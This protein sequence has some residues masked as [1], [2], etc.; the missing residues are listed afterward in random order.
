MKKLFQILLVVVLTSV[1][2]MA[3]QEKTVIGTVV[4]QSDKEPLIGATVMA[5]GTQ[6]GVATDIDGHFSLVIPSSVHDLRVSYV[7][8]ET[9][10]V[11]VDFNFPM[12]ISLSDNATKLDDVIVV[13]YGTAKKSEYTGAASVVSA[14]DIS[15]ALV[16][17][18]T[19][20]LQGK[21]SG[22]QTLSSDGRPGGQ[23]SV[24]IRGVGSINA[25]ND[26]L[27]V[28]DGVPY[29]GDISQLANSDIESMTVLKDAASTALYGARGANGVV[30]ITTKKG[31]TGEARVTLEAR[32]GQNA[33]ALDNYN[34]IKSP[35][36]YYEMLYQGYYNYAT[37]ERGADPAT[38]WNFA[39]NQIQPLNGTG[40][41][42]GYQIW[43]VPTG[44]RLV[45]HN[46][47]LNPNATLGYSDGQ[48]YY[49]PDDWT[50]G[51]I[52]KGLRQ[53]YN[54]GVSGGSEKFKYYVSASYLGDEGIIQ[55]SGFNRL[56]T[57]TTVDYQAKSW[58]KIGTNMAYI[59]TN[60]DFAGSQTLND[61]TSSGN[62]FY[63]VNSLAPIYPM[64]VRDASGSV[65]HN[66]TYNRPIYDY[67]DGYSTNFK[68]AYMSMSNPAGDQAYNKDKFLSDA[69][70]GKWFVTLTPIK[71]LNITGTAGFFTDNTRRHVVDNPFYGQSAESGGSAMQYASRTS[72]INLQALAS[73]S[74]TFAD[75]HNMD[76]MVGF[77]NY[78]LTREY[79]YGLGYN[80]Y[81][82][83][84]WNVSNVIDRK[85]TDGGRDI[86]YTTCGF[87]GRAKYNYDGRY[88]VQA[89]YRRD[90]SS[91]FAPGHRWGNFYSASVGWD[92]SREAF[93]RD[94]TAV[95][96]LKFKF[97][98]GQNGNDKLSADMGLYPQ[99][100]YAWQDQYQA[101]GAN[102]VWNDANLIYKG[103][104][105]ITWETSSAINTGFDFSFFHGRLD[106]TIEY[107]SRQTRNMLFNLPAAPSLGYSSYPANV[108]SMRNYGVEIELNGTL[109]RTRNVEWDV[110]FN[111]TTMGNKIIKLAD[112]LN[113]QWVNGGRIYAEGESM[114]QLYIPK[115]AGVNEQTGEAMYWAKAADGTEFKT[116]NWDDCYSG[117]AEK[118]L[119][120]NRYKTGSLLPKAY[121][122]FG[123]SVKAYGIDFSISFAYQFG[124]RVM[125]YTYQDFMHPVDDYN[126]GMN[127]HVDM[128]NAWTPENTKTNVPRI[129]AEDQYTNATS[130]RFL[131][132]SDFL[133]LNNITIG[134][135]L[136]KQW[137]D[138][139]GIESVRV[140]GAAEN[141]A[142]WTA[143]K[144]LD[145]RQGYVASQN[146]TYS[147]I[148][149]IS[150]GLR[151][152]F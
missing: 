85:T 98:F 23:P 39:N 26:P 44:E 16:S 50:K 72:S 108:G 120:A 42:T 52:G 136:P 35:A 5:V 128:L 55:G 125:D 83:T 87:F 3:Q 71:G 129:C 103:N 143:R 102:G 63:L 74:H 93:M 130:D 92:I 138:R 140:Y 2:A 15:D 20:V 18:V 132:S 60:T 99:Y 19:S 70:D 152:I 81:N 64:Y 17:S 111:I 62:A 90:A 38:A 13:A 148:R 73:Y 12:T 142:L 107:F 8:Y 104:R 7:G 68:R 47:R 61:A 36:R 117:N 66:A 37:M 123:T 29:E 109:V 6:I 40:G 150:G 69:F 84:G 24:R 86:D 75:V 41:A 10:T 4:S 94:V 95:D 32:W 118:G 31:S 43:T 27:Y 97:S 126:N 149:C 57:R 33:R 78:H 91:V 141:V 101:T 133:S 45:G 88:F 124:G 134:Y 53:E 21:V 82:P 1:S 131:V 22:V 96:Q 51:T 14:A 127:W 147:P 54:I 79:V 110:N 34:V 59:H 65:M 28:V 49:T 119:V 151:V 105:N 11:P 146:S 121:G 77:E 67:G 30:L 135:T 9:A 58:L 139:L 89:S 122:G 25:S 145:P 112:Y 144:G 56:S 100:Y 80:L 76:V 46:G 48:Y 106:G 113:G 137:T 115:W 114:Y 116:S